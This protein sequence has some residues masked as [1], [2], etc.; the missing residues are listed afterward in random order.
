[1]EDEEMTLA[2]EAKIRR[3]L[4]DRFWLSIADWLVLNRPQTAK[5]K[6]DPNFV[7]NAKEL[8]D[9]YS[10]CAFIS[11]LAYENHSVAARSTMERMH[12]NAENVVEKV[13]IEAAEYPFLDDLSTYEICSLRSLASDIFKGRVEPCL[14]LIGTFY[15]GLTQGTRVAVGAALDAA[16]APTNTCALPDVSKPHIQDKERRRLS[17]QFYTPPYVV[18]YCLETALQ[19]DSE[20]LIKRIKASA[21]S[22]LKQDIS[23]QLPADCFAICDPA[24]GTG[25]FLVGFLRWLK[26]RHFSSIEILASI[27]TSIFGMELDPR[28]AALA[29]CSLLLACLD[30]LGDFS[31]TELPCLLLKLIKQLGQHITVADTV[32]LSSSGCMT[33]QKQYDLIITNPP[34]V[35]YGARNQPKL[36]PS[37]AKFLKQEYAASAEYKIRLHSVFQECALRLTKSGGRAALLV[38]DAFLTGQ[39]Y[40]AL[41]RE[42]I[43]AAR[44]LSISE[45]PDDTIADAVVGQWCLAVYEKFGKLEEG[46]N[47]YDVD[48]YSVSDFSAQDSLKRYKLPF[49][50]FVGCDRNRFRLMFDDVDKLIATRLD[51]FESLRAYVRGH[52]GIRAT[53]GQEK[54][55]AS[56]PVTSTFRRGINS[57]AQVLRHRTKWSGI[58]IN[59]DPIN[60]YGGGFDSG[61]V[62]N[63]KLLVRQTGDRIIAAYDEEGFYHLNNVHSFSATRIRH[64]DPTAGHQGRKDLRYLDGLLNSNAWIYLYQMKTRENGRALAQ[65]DIESVESVVVPPPNQIWQSWISRL[66]LEYG[67]LIGSGQNNSDIDKICQMIDRCIDRLVY[68]LYGFTEPEVQ[69]I[70]NYCHNKARKKKDMSSDRSRLP[71]SDELGEWTDR[72]EKVRCLNVIS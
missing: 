13:F 16:L 62:E 65:V 49:S 6:S 42:I 25:N 40:Q 48:L 38:P 67:L 56:L 33:T 69:H 9:Q 36:A 41:R 5:Y 68:N 47:E 11:W 53:H 26:A 45:L 35:S 14:S 43:R 12:G 19:K 32:L 29:R 63:P 28:A 4:F 34:Y 60:L 37:S 66:V 24:C 58:W 54:I 17:G 18:D 71:H 44:V 57:G 8:C 51:Q 50:I 64:A 39:Y 31:T 21:Q 20:Q 61:V 2:A 46:Q 7:D 59:I 1:L 27:S 72:I 30:Q 23:S 55:I 22:S 15:E 52:T 70:E 3:Q 10:L